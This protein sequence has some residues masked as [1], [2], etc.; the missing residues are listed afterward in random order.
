MKML[1]LLIVCLTGL[2]VSP[3]RGDEPKE[4]DAVGIIKKL[5][6]DV[7]R[8]EK[9][10]GKPVVL[11]TF[12]STDLDDDG[13]KQAA[14][15]M[16]GMKGLQTLDISGTQVTDAGLKELALLKGLRKLRISAMPLTDAGLGVLK[17]LKDLEYLD[18]NATKVTDKGVKDL[19]ALKTLKQLL[20][21]GSEVTDKGF[22]ELKASLPDCQILGQ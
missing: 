10:P 9:A 15:A 17:E 19:A 13:L 20:L 7:M 14:K 22:N 2:A 5:G 4:D 6:G 18:L 3:L 11:V 8:D 1:A 12:A 21:L 16:A